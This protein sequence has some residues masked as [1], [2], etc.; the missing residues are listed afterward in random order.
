LRAVMRSARHAMMD[1]RTIRRLSPGSTADAKNMPVLEIGDFSGLRPS[2]GSADIR[3]VIDHPDRV[4]LTSSGPVPR[5]LGPR[6]AR[7]LL[8]AAR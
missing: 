4:L 3:N 1:H 8:R 5:R 2:V 7:T 6:M